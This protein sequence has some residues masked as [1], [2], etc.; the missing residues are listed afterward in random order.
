MR[1]KDWDQSARYVLACSLYARQLVTGFGRLDSGMEGRYQ[2]QS[3][4]GG[5][6]GCAP[7]LSCMSADSAT[8]HV[9]KGIASQAHA[10]NG[11]AKGRG[12]PCGGKFM[13]RRRSWRQEAGAKAVSYGACQSRA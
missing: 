8:A 5:W 12:R 9:R 11:G 4:R 7:L 10:R 2:A 6:K 3:R 1:Q 13:R